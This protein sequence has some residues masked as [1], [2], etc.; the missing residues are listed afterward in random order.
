MFKER[1]MG[2]GITVTRNVF[3]FDHTLGIWSFEINAFFR[4]ATL[5]AKF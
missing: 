1:A 3:L 4:W 5:S 2:G